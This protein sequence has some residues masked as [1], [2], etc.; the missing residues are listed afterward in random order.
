MVINAEI[1]NFYRCCTYQSS[2]SCTEDKSSG[3]YSQKNSSIQERRYQTY[4]VFSCPS[5]ILP[6]QCQ[7]IIRLIIIVLVNC[8][9][10][11]GSDNTNIH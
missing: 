3:I 6:K 1:P 7:E 4:K 9:R 11:S 8:P 2:I 5:E 10:N